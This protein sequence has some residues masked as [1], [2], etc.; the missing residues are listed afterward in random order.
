MFRRQN[1]L[2][3]NVQVR[4][5]T[6]TPLRLHY[7]S[8]KFGKI[9]MNLFYSWCS[10]GVKITLDRCSRPC[11]ASLGC[12]NPLIDPQKSAKNPTFFIYIQFIPTADK[13]LAAHQCRHPPCRLATHVRTTNAACFRSV[14]TQRVICVCSE[15][16][17]CRIST[18]CSSRDS[19]YQSVFVI[20]EERR[21]CAI[22]TEVS[23]KNKCISKYF[24][25]RQSLEM[26]HVVPCAPSFTEMTA[27]GAIFC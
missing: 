22:A 25:K 2:E 23:P 5:T 7:I 18:I 27:D 9:C 13:R 12:V 15:K 21:E 10:C 8:H 24:N 20:A 19:M 11:S 4:A 16:P 26:H 17:E 3:S 6:L 1:A 14:L